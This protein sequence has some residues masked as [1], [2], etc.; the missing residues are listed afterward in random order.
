MTVLTPSSGGRAVSPLTHPTSPPTYNA[1]M[2]SLRASLTVLTLLLATTPSFGQQVIEFTETLDFDRPESWAMKYFASLSI[3]TGMGVPEALDPGGVS[4][5]FEG[6]I[7]PY[8]TEAQQTVGFE[9]TKFEDMNRTRFFGRVRARVGLGRKTAI[10]LGYVPPI[11]VNRVTPHLFAVGAGRPFELAGA[12]QLG[13][14]G[15]AQFGTIDGDITCSAREIESGQNAFGCEAPSEDELSQKIYGA[16]LTAGYVEGKWRP[17]VGIAF[18]Y[19]DLEFQ[20]N[21]RYRGLIDHSLQR[22][23]GGAVS[24]TGGVSFVA[25]EQWRIS[26]ELFYTP[27]S[28]ARPPSTSSENDGLFNARFL[29][30]Y[31]LR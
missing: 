14:R 9:G 18:H 5:G 23:D 25:N 27:L 1:G 24:F 4:L 22:T 26:G 20:V 8:L 10:E 3:L 31:R 11:E 29:V 30:V 2:T 17:H 16:E 13:V 12:W 15:Y 21:A 6:G 28:V 19:L 7:V